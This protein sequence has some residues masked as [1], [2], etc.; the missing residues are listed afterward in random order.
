MDEV[1]EA[2]TDR[3][4][5]DRAWWE[6]QVVQTRQE[7]NDLEVKLEHLKSEGIRSPIVRKEREA[8][9]EFAKTQD[10]LEKAKGK[11]QVDLPEA[12]AKAGAPAS[13]LVVN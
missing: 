13:W 9:R 8:R 3:D 12:A 5:H 4:G 1:A 11:L 10:E 6:S 2:A 7:I